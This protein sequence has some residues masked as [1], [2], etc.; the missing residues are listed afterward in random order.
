M[1][2]TSLVYVKKRILLFTSLTIKKYLQKANITEIKKTV[3]YQPALP[4]LLMMYCYS[5]MRHACLLAFSNASCCHNNE[6]LTSMED[7]A[8]Q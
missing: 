8:V 1:Q 3:Y 2:F 7:Q 5:N 6:I 4:Y